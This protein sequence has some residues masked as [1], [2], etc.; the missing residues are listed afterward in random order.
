MKSPMKTYIYFLFLCIF[1]LPHFHQIIR[2]FNGSYPFHSHSNHAGL[3][4]NTS[5]IKVQPNAFFLWFKFIFIF[6]DDYCRFFMIKLSNKAAL[7]GNTWAQKFKLAQELMRE[8][9]VVKLLVYILQS[10]EKMLRKK[11]LKYLN[12][13]PVSVLIRPILYTEFP[14]Y[15]YQNSKSSDFSTLTTF[16]NVVFSFSQ[17]KGDWLLIHEKCGQ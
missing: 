17:L 1:L 2:H 5:E 6:I 11:T 9:K 7:R 16:S 13:I 4:M 12:Q 10:S 14:L 3:T 15:R 8:R